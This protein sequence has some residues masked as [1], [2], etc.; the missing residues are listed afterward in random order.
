MTVFV[1]EDADYAFPNSGYKV[2]GVL[3]YPAL[4]VLGSLTITDHNTI[5]VQ[6]ASQP[7]PDP[8][9]SKASG[10]PFFLDGDQIVAA[11]GEPGDER[12]FVVD[13]GSQQTYMTSRY[14]AEHMDEF[15]GKRQQLFNMPAITGL[16]PQPAYVAETVALP[17]GANTAHVH[18]VLVYTQPFRQSALDDVYGVLGIDALDQ[19]TSYTFDYRTMRFSVRP[20]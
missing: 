5:E 9:S 15:A 12:M 13:A 17:I 3:G 2:Q 19:L 6:P 8:V 11:L 10:V 18:F 14:Y 1:Y 4:A 7:Q 20:E 16:P